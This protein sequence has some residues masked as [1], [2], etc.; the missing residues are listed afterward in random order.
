MR[1]AERDLMLVLL[2]VAA[3]SADSWSYFGLGHAFVA[4]MTG[5]TVLLGIAVTLHRDLLHPGI[6]LGCYMVGAALAAFLTRNIHEVGGWPRAVSKTLVL[7]SA[8]LIAAAIGWAIVGRNAV[9]PGSRPDLNALL[10]C[11]AVAIGIQSGAMLQLKIP[12]VVTTYITGTWTTLT[13]SLTRFFATKRHEPRRQKVAYEERMLMQA[14]V[15]CAY[16]LS[17]IATGLLFLH[18]RLAVGA[19]PALSVLL[20][21]VYGLTRKSHSTA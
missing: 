14:G 16:L 9:E 19:L 8:L 7:E 1:Q 20:V 21:A 6:S 10:G 3:G 12:G 2:A 18:A 15:L 13:S 17:A 5:N 11:V 4:N